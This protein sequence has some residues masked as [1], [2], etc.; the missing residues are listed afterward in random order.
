MD[1]KEWGLFSF[2]TSSGY[3]KKN[4]MDIDIEKIKDLYFNNGYIK[5]ALGE[6]QIQLT[7]DKKGMFITIT[8]SEGDQYKVSS[9]E[10]T[11]N[12]VFTE[13]VVRK[14]ITMAP[15]KPFSK[16][17]L[18]KDIFSISELYSETGYALITVTPDVIPDESKKLV[19]LVLNIR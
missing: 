12:K 13:D 18:R 17:N 7:S 8:V 15:D 5:V 4:Q 2:I 9:I 16:E 11:G 19:K 1:T 10:L 3:Y 14:R 6:P